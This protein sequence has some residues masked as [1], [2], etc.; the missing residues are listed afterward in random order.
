MHARP[1]FVSN[2]TFEIISF[3]EDDIVYRRRDIE[4]LDSF[5]EKGLKN[6]TLS[7]FCDYSWLLL[8]RIDKNGNLAAV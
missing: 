8:M 1:L 7:E 3:W 5:E 6:F 4:I 2:A